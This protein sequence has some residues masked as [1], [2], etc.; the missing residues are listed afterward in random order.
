MKIIQIASLV[1]P[2]GAYGGPVRVAVNQTRALLASGHNVVLAA[3]AEGY[4]GELPKTFDGVPVKLFRARNVVPRSGFAGVIA[5][6]LQKWLIGNID[7]ADVLHVHMSRD[8]VTLPTAISASRRGR[9]YVVQTHGMIAESTHPLA[10]PLDALWTKRALAGAGRVFYLTPTERAGLEVVGSSGLRLQELHNG[11]PEL[12]DVPSRPVDALEV[13]FLARLHRRKRPQIFV[14][15]A[16][17]LHKRFPTVRFT[18]V[19]PDEGEGDMVR[20]AIAEAALSKVVSWEGPV[21]P[22]LSAERI[23]RCAVYVLPSVDEPFPMSVLEAM[24]L[25]KPVVVTDTCGLSAAIH[26]YQAGSVVGADLTSL[27]QAVEKLLLSPLRR[28]ETGANARKLAVN[29]FGMGRVVDELTSAYEEVA[30]DRT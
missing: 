9:P 22:D 15:M 16:R 27:V 1:T 6:G 28:T 2:D 12:A 10:R 24:R 7:S 4:R 26:Q 29:R 18:L 3:G 5:P 14:D 30:Q 17:I 20:A 21:R 8:L 19:G 25:G 13:L 23:S 11:V